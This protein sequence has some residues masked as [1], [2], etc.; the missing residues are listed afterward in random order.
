MSKR[1][2]K[3]VSELEALQGDQARARAVRPKSSREG[4]AAWIEMVLADADRIRTAGAVAE[5]DNVKVERSRN[6]LEAAWWELR[7]W[8]DLLTEGNTATSDYIYRQ[9]WILSS[10]IT[11]IAASAY[12]SES[13]INY[14][15]RLNAKNMRQAREVKTSRKV[16]QRREAIMAVATE[17]KLPLV[18]SEEFAEIIRDG[19]HTRIGGERKPSAETLKRDIRAIREQQKTG[20]HL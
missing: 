17:M 12:L 1:A 5:A 11:L 10:S 19:V 18:I 9:L 20:S 14:S 15:E 6:D 3:H 2:S 13:S 4:A 16:A 8:V 7:K